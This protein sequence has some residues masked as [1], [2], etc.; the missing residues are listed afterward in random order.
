M[1]TDQGIRDAIA[2]AEDAL[3]N[4]LNRIGAQPGQLE[5][6]GELDLALRYEY[7]QN[8]HDEGTDDAAP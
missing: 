7:W 4:K 8:E 5:A 1:A 6:L 2:S 3:F